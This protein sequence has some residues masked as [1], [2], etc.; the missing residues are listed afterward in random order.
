LARAAGFEPTLH[1]F[2]D[3]PTAVILRP[4]TDPQIRTALS[5]STNRRHHQIGLIG[6]FS[7]IPGRADRASPESRK[8]TNPDVLDCGLARLRERPGMTAEC[9]VAGP[10]DDPGSVAL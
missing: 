6:K 3:R 5:G 1:G 9:L 7:V 2:G 4:R 10:G 8:T